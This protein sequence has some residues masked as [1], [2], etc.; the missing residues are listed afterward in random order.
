M[1]PYKKF[2]FERRKEEYQMQHFDFSPSQFTHEVKEELMA[3]VEEAANALE[4]TICQKYPDVD[5]EAINLATRN[6]V[7]AY[8]TAAEEWGPSFQERM[9]SNFLCIPS[10]V[11]LEEDKPQEVQYSRE[12]VEKI[13]QD[14]SDL[15]KKVIASKYLKAKL[16]KTLK[17][18]KKALEE[19]SKY[20]A[21]SQTTVHSVRPLI[22]VF[23]GMERKRRKLH[24]LIDSSLLEQE[25][26]QEMSE[27][28]SLG[29]KHIPL[30]SNGKV[31]FEFSKILPPI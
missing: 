8:S 9:D 13:D 18:A 31:N 19:Q 29:K 5:K 26:N 6:V 2:L 30:N 25:S 21:S 1:D 11:L 14:I 15:E 10:H 23:D 27:S 7:K 16:S 28:E 12:E 3:V 24:Y 17:Q 20:K 4:R 22:G